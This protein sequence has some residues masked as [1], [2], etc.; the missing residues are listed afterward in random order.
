MFDI[1][2]ADLSDLSLFVQFHFN[3]IAQILHKF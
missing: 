1:G 2:V 3:L